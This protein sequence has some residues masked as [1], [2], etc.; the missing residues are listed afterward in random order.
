MTYIDR[1]RDWLGRTASPRRMGELLVIGHGHGD[2]D[3]DAASYHLRHWRDL[4]AKRDALR[5]VEGW[6]AWR[7]LLRYAPDGAFR[8]LKASP[9]LSRGWSLGPL[10]F[11]DLV[12]ALQYAYPS[13]LAN[14]HEREAGTL[15]VTPYAETAARQTGRF[16][17]VAQVTPEQLGELVAMHC[18]NGCLKCRQWAP[19]APGPP[20]LHGAEESLPAPVSRAMESAETIPLLCPEACNWF[21]GKARELL[22][23][24]MED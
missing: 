2:G 3:K 11:D 21:V 20:P 10:G 14:W 1:F 24:P 22:K 15:P 16:N 13:E 12:L 5:P 17:V 7:E 23:G 8:P 19:D 9:N 4:V 6:A 18:A